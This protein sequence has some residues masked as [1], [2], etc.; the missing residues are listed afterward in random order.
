MNERLLR[1]LPGVNERLLRLLP[2]VKERLLRLLPGDRSWDYTANIFLHRRRS[3]TS[4]KASRIECL[5]QL[6]TAHPVPP[7]LV[8][9]WVHSK[10]ILV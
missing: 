7:A 2:G 4:S 6:V 1:L 8:P 9:P 10:P 3:A 5:F